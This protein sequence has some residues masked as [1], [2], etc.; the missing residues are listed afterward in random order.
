MALPSIKLPG[1]RINYQVSGSGEP[2]LMMRGYGSHLGWWD[3]EFISILEESFQLILYDHRGT[4]HSVHTSGDYS[5]LTLAK[6][7]AGLVE[8]LGFEKVNV[9]GLS[10]GGMVAQELA[11]AWPGRI[12]SLVLG[13]THCGGATLVPPSPEV[14]QIMLERA[15][16]GRREPID[17]TWLAI[18]FTPAFLLENP[19]AVKAYLERAAKLPTDPEIISLQAQAAAVFDACNRDPA[20]TSPTWILHGQFD[21]IVPVG[22]A[23]V[24]QSHIPFSRI[25]ILPGLG[26]D[27]TVQSPSYAAWLLTNIIQLDEIIQP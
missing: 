3:P 8:K 18:A 21:A 26:H 4:G 2:L 1:G 27:F 24:L 15:R 17:E 19:R 22:N 10:L 23:F 7:A 14:M 16:E 20:I 25:L 11:I 9:F 12:K 5:I 13:A 6:D